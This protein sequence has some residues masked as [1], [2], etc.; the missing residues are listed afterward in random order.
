MLLT[1]SLPLLTR[2]LHVTAM[3]YLFGGAL[4]L[5][6]LF[7]I[8]TPQLPN[9]RQIFILKAAEIYETGSWMALG[10]VVL[11]GVGNLGFFGEGLPGVETTWGTRLALKLITLFLYLLFALY[12]T[13]LIA[14]IRRLYAGNPDST[15]V[16]SLSRLY[17]GTAIFLL[18]ILTE[19]MILSH[20]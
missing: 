5:W 9:D 20:G 1:I 6:V 10:L 7:R 11:S 3:A 4:L 15:R 8:F 14:G 17:A 18:I 19:A 13:L 16:H 12:R 2:L